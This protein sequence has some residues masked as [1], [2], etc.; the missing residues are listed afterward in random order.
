[1]VGINTAV[2]PYARGIGFAVP[3]RTASWVAA[4]L[5][6]K[7]EVRRPRIGVLA[8]SE[9]LASGARAVRVLRVDAGAP[10]ERAGLH[11]GDLL[12]RANDDEI[13]TLDDLQRA[14]ALG[15]TSE[16]RLE[17][18]RGDASRSLSVRPESRRAA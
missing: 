10:A 7:G 18:R 16:L 6:Q 1:V 2:V 17:V 9:E 13:A 5:I 15:G 4:V 14:L 11:G 8:R 12:L 3:A